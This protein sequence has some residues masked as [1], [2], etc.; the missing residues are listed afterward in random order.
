MIVGE[1]TAVL[2]T[3][4]LPETL[5]A[6]VGLYAAVKVGPGAKLAGTVIPEIVTFATDG[7]RLEILTSEVP[8]FC[9]R[10]VCV[11]SLPTTT[12]PKLKDEGVAASVEDVAVPLMPIT[13]LESLA[14]LVTVTLPVNV[15]G[16][17][18]L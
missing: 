12:L 1:P 14:L 11:V 13:M 15:V 2:V 4:I 17:V 16:D 5:P 18:G 7:V 6:A 10:I 9:K 3:V 8:M